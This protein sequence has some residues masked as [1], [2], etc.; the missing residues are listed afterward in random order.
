MS[1]SQKTKN[2][3]AKVISEKPC[4]QLAE[5][6][7]LI[8]SI[9]VLHL[10]EKRMSLSFHTENSAVGRK[11]FQ[12][13]KKNFSLSP[14]II[15]RR[16]LLLRKNNVYEILIDD[17]QAVRNVLEKLNKEDALYTNLRL[18]DEKMIKKP[19][20]QRAYLRG[21]FLGSGSLS[22]PEKTY[23]LEISGDEDHY[24][25]MVMKLMKSFKLRVGMNK[26]KDY[27]VVY[28]KD[29]EAIVTFLNLTGAHTA[30]L[31]LESIRVMKEV[32]NDINRLVNCET[33]NLSKTVAAAVEQKGLIHYIDNTVGIDSLPENLQE[34]ARLRIIHPEASLKELGELLDQPLGKSGVR[35]RMDRIKDMAEKIMKRNKK[36]AGDDSD[37]RATKQDH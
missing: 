32:R 30:L 15:V 14:E 17:K 16:Q 5:L 24:C 37:E 31:D 11:I 19:C 7:A 26:R 28:L 10:Y 22:N 6:A 18:E 29:A 27:C 34:I 20:C 4:C 23:H 13:L 9:G 36:K 3:L 8:R 35:H 33:A 25:G 21:A 2:E 1:F 12:L